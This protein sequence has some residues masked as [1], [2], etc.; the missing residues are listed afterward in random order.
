M[1]PRRV[2]IAVIIAIIVVP[3]LILVPAI[4]FTM[5]VYTGLLRTQPLPPISCS[6]PNNVIDPTLLYHGYESVTRFF[7]G[8]GTLVYTGCNMPVPQ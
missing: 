8:I 2:A 5:T 1:K 3:I 6:V 4:P 7:T